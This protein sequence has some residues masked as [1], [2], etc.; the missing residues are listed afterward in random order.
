MIQLTGG[1]YSFET[2]QVEHDQ[3][4]CVHDALYTGLG[5][6]SNQARGNSPGTEIPPTSVPVLSRTGLL[7][8][9]MLMLGMDLIGIRRYA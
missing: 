8:L 4:C 9:D 3:S 7:A 1:V 2:E 6:I 5:N